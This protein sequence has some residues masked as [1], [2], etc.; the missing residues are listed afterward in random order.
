MVAMMS[1]LRAIYKEALHST[2]PNRH[3]HEPNLP[4]LKRLIAITSSR[5]TFHR[6]SNSFLLSS[7]T[8][9]EHAKHEGN[10]Y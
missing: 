5:Y 6:L 1:G 8:R 3:T 9:S 4:T 2:L 7:S 10:R